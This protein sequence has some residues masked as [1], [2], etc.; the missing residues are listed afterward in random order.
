MFKN[1]DD[2]E[3]KMKKKRKRL[4]KAQIFFI[5]ILI[6]I[7][8]SIIYLIINNYYKKINSIKYDHYELY[9]YFSGAKIEYDGVLSIEYN[10]NV[11]KIESKNKKVDTGFI[12]IYFQKIKNQVI[13]P[14]NME[15]IF[16]KYKN[17]NYRLKYLTKLV[18]DTIDNEE[19]IFIED[20]NKKI[21]LEPSFL[22]NG[23]DLYFFPY[24]TKI[25]V[26]DKEYQLSPLSYIIVNYKDLIEIYNKDE[27]KYT[28]IDTHE[29]DVIAMV[30]NFKI[31]LSTD[32]IM[33]ENENR[34]L[35]KKVDKLP[36]YK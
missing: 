2:F 22:Y 18:N 11:T 16:P 12:P 29:N 27:D 36:L 28:I 5:S 21:Y 17:K 3:I 32:M 35:L 9:Q 23:E 10:N 14:V 25:I 7:S 20:N 15:L 26:D 8:I 31:N 34:L 30:E 19:T 4:K 1:N 33:Y 24:S 6:I 13:F